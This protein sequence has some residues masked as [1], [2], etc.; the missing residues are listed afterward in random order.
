MWAIIQVSFPRCKYEEVYWK[1]ILLFIYA[2]QLVSIDGC[3]FCVRGFS[4]G[5][6]DVAKQQ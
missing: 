5:K 2:A 3:G 6:S 1:I 4:V